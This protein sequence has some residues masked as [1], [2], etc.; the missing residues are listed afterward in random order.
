MAAILVY[1][2]IGQE[3]LDNSS[4][5]HY[6]DLLNIYILRLRDK[7]FGSTSII[8]LTQSKSA[9]NLTINTSILVS[10]QNRQNDTIMFFLVQ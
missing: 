3:S 7:N 6:K 10:P 5:V 8:F 4:S 2:R 9:K 1:L